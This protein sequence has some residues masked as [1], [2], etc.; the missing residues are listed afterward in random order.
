MIVFL[1]VKDQ[2]RVFDPFTVEEI[3]TMDVKA[4]GLVYHSRFTKADSFHH[5]F[6]SHKVSPSAPPLLG[7]N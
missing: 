2:L 6:R 4:L 7:A 3:E 5:S 1:N